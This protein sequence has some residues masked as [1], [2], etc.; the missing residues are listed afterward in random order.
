M[1]HQINESIAIK[2]VAFYKAAYVITKEENREI[3]LFGDF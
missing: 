2:E 3:I 1:H